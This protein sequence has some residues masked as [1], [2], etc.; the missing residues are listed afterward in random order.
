MVRAKYLDGESRDDDPEIDD[1]IFV[2]VVQHTFTKSPKAYDFSETGNVGEVISGFG[3]FLAL[4]CN[5]YRDYAD[6]TVQF[7]VT[8]EE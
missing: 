5:C 6:T 8:R 7:F 3:I 2:D 1:A 4:T